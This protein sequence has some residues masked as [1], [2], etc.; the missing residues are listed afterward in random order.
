MRLPDSAQK[1]LSDYRCQP[2][3]FYE[4]GYVC[5]FCDGSVHDEPQQKRE[6]QRI[7]SDLINKGFRVV[8][9]R[10]DQPIGEQVDEDQDI[11]GVAKQ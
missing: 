1:L 2:D 7:R 11:F 5:V 9:I 6:D 8:V 3:F 4:D 10:Y